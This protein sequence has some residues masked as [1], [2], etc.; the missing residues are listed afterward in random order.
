MVDGRLDEPARLSPGLLERLAEPLFALYRDLA[1]RFA[2]SGEVEVGLVTRR[3]LIELLRGLAGRLGDPVRIQ[4]ASALSDLAS[5]LVAADRVDEADAAAAEAAAT[6]PSG[7]ETAV[8]DLARGVVNRGSQLITWTPLPASASFAPRAAS[9][10][11]IKIVDQSALDAEL[12]RQ[13]ATWLQ[14]A[15]PEAHRLELER[16]EHARIEAELSEAQRVAAE[17]SA[18]EKRAAEAAKAAEA[19]RVE[20]ERQAAAE[21]AERLER[22]RRR[23]E[24]IEAHRLEIEKREAERRDAERREAERQAAEAADPAEAERLELE[25]LQAELDELERAEQLAR[26]KE[27]PS[28]TS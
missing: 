21:E 10:A 4:L 14:S 20:A 15:R 13:L 2:A 27:P 12:Q 6:T 26:E 3:R 5:D 25:R 23:E 9:V 28:A 17:R 18:A 24:R 1:D 7:S 8:Q 22:K 11:A 19:E 16:M